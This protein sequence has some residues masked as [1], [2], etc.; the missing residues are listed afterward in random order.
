MFH[1]NCFEKHLSNLGD[2]IAGMACNFKLVL[3]ISR[4]ATSYS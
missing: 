4:Y 2:K 3:L 1:R